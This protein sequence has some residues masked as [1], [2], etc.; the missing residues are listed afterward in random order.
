MAQSKRNQQLKNQIDELKLL[1]PSVIFNLDKTTFNEEE[2]NVELKE[3]VII[4][5]IFPNSDI[6][7][8][9]AY[10]IEINLP[11]VYPLYPPKVRFLTPIYHPNVDQDGMYDESFYEKN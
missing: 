7:K 10:E 3:H 6:F 5:R 2:M 1:A 11:L 4:G 9:G 8:E